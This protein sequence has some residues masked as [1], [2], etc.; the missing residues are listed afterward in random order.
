MAA[1]QTD[2]GVVKSYRWSLVDGVYL[3]EEK[4]IDSGDFARDDY[5][6]LG[7][8]LKSKDK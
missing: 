3:K 4:N 6:F 7:W 8:A 1:L 2:V 5:N